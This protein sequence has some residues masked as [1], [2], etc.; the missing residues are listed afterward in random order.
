MNAPSL[1]T[2]LMAKCRKASICICP[3]HLLAA[4]HAVRRSKPSPKIQS[5]RGQ[6]EYFARDSKAVPS[7]GGR[8]LGTIPVGC[9]EQPPP[10]DYYAVPAMIAGAS[11][12]SFVR[13]VLFWAAPLHRLLP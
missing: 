10:D 13:R 3:F 9:S 11:E 4:D 2:E 8:A 12:P 7:T 5:S 1:V 6:A